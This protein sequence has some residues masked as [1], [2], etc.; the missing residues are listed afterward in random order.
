MNKKPYSRAANKFY[1]FSGALEWS[2]SNFEKYK[3]A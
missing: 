3:G 2:L 1:C